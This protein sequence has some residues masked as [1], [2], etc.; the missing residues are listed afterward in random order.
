MRESSNRQRRA[1]S[2]QRKYPDAVSPKIA[3]RLLPPR[4]FPDRLLDR[5]KSV[6]HSRKRDHC[7]KVLK[8]HA[9]RGAGNKIHRNFGY[10]LGARWRRS[11]QVDVFGLE[12]HRGIG[13][14]DRRG[15]GDPQ[16]HQQRLSLP[17]DMVPLAA[18]MLS[19]AL[20]EAMRRRVSSGVRNRC[21]WTS[22]AVVSPAVGFT[23][24]PGTFH[25]RARFWWFRRRIPWSASR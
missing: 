10:Q 13:G 9:R 8:G 7:P 5:S 11:N 25:F 4:R 19:S 24:A 15:A 22:G 18:T 1:G 20:M 3:Q 17:V 14:A 12:D 23:L 16:R 6:E 21:R 2:R